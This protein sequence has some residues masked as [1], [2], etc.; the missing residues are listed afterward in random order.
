MQLDHT[1]PCSYYHLPVASSDIELTRL[2]LECS[3]PGLR[4]PYAASSVCFWRD[5]PR[6]HTQ[7]P[8]TGSLVHTIASSRNTLG[9]NTVTEAGNIL[10]CRPLVFPCGSYLASLLPLVPLQMDGEG[11]NNSASGQ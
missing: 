7:I 2:P 10:C 5:C 8:W 4:I 9:L 1:T 3:Y 11:L 6:E